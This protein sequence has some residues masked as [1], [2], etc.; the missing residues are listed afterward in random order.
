MLAPVGCFACSV[1]VSGDTVVFVLR[2]NRGA[3]RRPG[4]EIPVWEQRC[5]DAIARW[6]SSLL[7]PLTGSFLDSQ[8]WSVG[9][10]AFKT[11]SFC[12]WFVFFFPFPQQYS[13]LSLSLWQW[14]PVTMG[15]LT[16]LGGS[17]RCLSPLGCDASRASSPFTAPDK[18]LCVRVRVVVTFN[19]TAWT[20][21]LNTNS[22][23]RFLS[24]IRSL[25]FLCSHTNA[26]HWRREGCGD[27]SAA[28]PG[29]SSRAWEAPE[30]HQR[31]HG[32]S[33]LWLCP[34]PCVLTTEK[35]V[36]SELVKT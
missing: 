7:N 10:Q 29:L 28:L 20:S 18:A 11:V 15:L 14:Y 34:L 23:I 17:Y 6:G 3:S 33:V 31:S 35:Q 25:S 4:A 24:H 19:I 22:Q 27:A 21:I 16:S 32:L 26:P 36:A 9:F 30:R 8:V 1:C 12:F 13:F 5:L 2:S